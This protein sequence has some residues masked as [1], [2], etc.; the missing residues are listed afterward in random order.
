MVRPTSPEACL[1]QPFCCSDTPLR[2][3]VEVIR[4]PGATRRVRLI[5]SQCP[6]C[7]T[8]HST[9]AQREANARRVLAAAA[10]IRRTPPGYEEQRIKPEWLPAVRLLTP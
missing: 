10:T 1:K 8:V 3:H 5:G 7:H 9:A 6:K 2:P 4:F